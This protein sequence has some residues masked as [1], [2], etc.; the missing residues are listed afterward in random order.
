MRFKNT[1]I[2]T[3][4]R[5]YVSFVDFLF[6]SININ[7]YA[8][9]GFTV[10]TKAQLYFYLFVLTEQH[11]MHMVTTNMQPLSETYDKITFDG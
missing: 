4:L 2:R 7:I 5:F 6:L 1:V 11:I 3:S 10:Y 9:E 8:C